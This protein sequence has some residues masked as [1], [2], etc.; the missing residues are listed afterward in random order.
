MRSSIIFLLLSCL[1]T[2]SLQQKIV[3]TNDDGWAVAQIRA[4]Y[5]ALRA[6]GFQVVLSAPA[7]NRSGT[8]SSTAPP[9]VLTQP[10]EFDTC[11]T[12]SPP[13]GAN[14]TDPFLNYVNSFPVD[15]VRFGIQTLAPRLL[16]SKPDFVVS[17]SNVGSKTNKIFLNHNYRGAASEAV[18]EGVPSIAFSGASA[19]AVSYTTLTSSP[20]S[21][22]TLAAMTYT[23]LTLKFI[24]TLIA[25]PGPILPP[26]VSVNVNYAS[27]S[28]CPTAP[29]FSFVFTRI[30][31][32]T[33][34]TDVVTCGTDHLP[35]ESSTIRKGCFATVSVFNATTKAD[36]SA[37]TQAVVLNKIQS[38]LT[39]LPN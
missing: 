31:V 10:C 15:A 36:V 4:E 24:Q 3:L 25:N 32:N 30:A 5:D 7:E 11:P 27:T 39:C 19:P 38:I 16:G 12:G 18:L 22:G 23:S 1:A 17:G 35:D 29:S 26:G 2:N 8:G 14:A 13:E 9:T 28:S 33:A 34:A 37:V 21:S 20:N 6:A